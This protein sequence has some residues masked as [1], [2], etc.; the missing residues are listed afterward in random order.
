MF[1]GMPMELPS[2]TT[3]TVPS[4]EGEKLFIE[5]T[6]FQVDGKSPAAGIVLY[7]YQTDNKGKYT[8]SKDQK[9]GRRHG[10]IRG[11]VKS[12]EKGHYA[13]TTIRPASY[14]NSRNPQHIHPIIL[15]SS[16]RY[17]WID[18]YL[19]DDDPVLPENEKTRNNPRGGSGLLHL[20]KNAQGIWIGK[21]DIILGRNV[22][23]YK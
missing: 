11:W 22:P 21:R 18:E 23:G 10:H 20:T 17:Y 5:G 2:S 9:N 3:L 19:F 13:F 4:D 8:P 7:V 1:Q 16:Q 14:P 15:E 6:I 12:D